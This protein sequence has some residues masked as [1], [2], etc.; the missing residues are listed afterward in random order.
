MWVGEKKKGS[1]ELVDYVTRC[2][3][4]T[5]SLF[6][7]I[8]K[9]IETRIYYVIIQSNTLAAQH[10]YLSQYFIVSALSKKKQQKTN[11]VCKVRYGLLNIGLPL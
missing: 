2:K 6:P 11:S 4:E 8:Y 9:H 1:R 5:T 3:P 7:S 10:E